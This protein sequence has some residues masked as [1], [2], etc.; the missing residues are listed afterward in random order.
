MTININEVFPLLETIYGQQ[1]TISDKLQELTETFKSVP[2][3]VE[4]Q[5]RALLAPISEGI[6]Q[7]NQTLLTTSNQEDS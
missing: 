3:P 1:Q 6:A 4:P 7:M 5:L 2:E